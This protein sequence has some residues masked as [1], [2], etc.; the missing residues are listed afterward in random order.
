MRIIVSDEMPQAFDSVGLDIRGA[1]VQSVVR[2]YFYWDCLL[3]RILSA[4]S[5]AVAALISLPVQAAFDPN[6]SQIA[7][8]ASIEPGRDYTVEGDVQ[9][10]WETTILLH[11]RSG[12]IVVDFGQHSPYGMGLR[13]RDY[14]QVSGHLQ[15]GHFAPTVLV[16]SDGSQI[17]FTGSSTYAPL[18]QADV[19]RNTNN[20]VLTPDQIA[21][22]PA[23]AADDAATAAPAPTARA[24]AAAPTPA[25]TAPEET[26]TPETSNNVRPVD[27]V[28]PSH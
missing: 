13:A 3:M 15:N 2:I 18:G 20:W 7:P 23:A 1:A 25:A 24:G 11:D 27:Q 6:G 14:V 4:L 9:T 21:V 22:P 5:L 10:L 17:L 26:A 8:I 19:D 28:Q 12:E 16:K